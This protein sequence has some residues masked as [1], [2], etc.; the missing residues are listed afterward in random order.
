[1]ICNLDYFNYYHHHDHEHGCHHTHH[2]DHD[3]ALLSYM[4][5]HN[6]H[7]MAELMECAQSLKAKGAESAA[8]L[9]EA[10]AE[11]L[12]Q[13]NVKLAEAINALGKGNA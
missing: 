11:L 4:L 5:D 12:K 9:T 6:E 13:S 1:M 2:D 10:S 7:H 8:K 3:A